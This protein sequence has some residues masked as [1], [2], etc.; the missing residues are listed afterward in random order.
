MNLSISKNKFNTSLTSPK[1]LN[2]SYDKKIN[3][4]NVYHHKH[5]NSTANQDLN[6]RG[7]Y[8]KTNN[9][10]NKSSVLLSDSDC[11]NINTS[12]EYSTDK[13]TKNPLAADRSHYKS[14]YK[15][16]EKR[17]SRNNSDEKHKEKEKENNNNSNN[18][19]NSNIEKKNKL[20]SEKLNYSKSV[21]YEDNIFNRS[22]SKN[23][24]DNSL[25]EFNK[26]ENEE[27]TSKRVANIIAK[28]K[29]I[30]GRS[31]STRDVKKIK[32][33]NSE[34]EKIKKNNIFTVLKTDKNKSEKIDFDAESI[35][36]DIYNEHELENNELFDLG[37]I[38]SK[39]FSNKKIKNVSKNNSVSK[40]KSK[41][42]IKT[43]KNAKNKLYPYDTNSE[44][45]LTFTN[46]DTTKNYSNNLHSYE[47]T[48]RISSRKIKN[49]F[50]NII[51]NTNS[52]R[53]LTGNNRSFSIH[54]YSNKIKNIQTEKEKILKLKERNNEL[55]LTLK[56]E[57]KKVDD[58]EK[59]NKRIK[60]K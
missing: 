57:R 47:T 2:Q 29:D 41:R 60:F 37:K 25:S 26:S 32:T 45:C 53:L 5:S 56:N 49:T 30:L 52:N 14:P 22:K 35:N 50:T 19:N 33:K 3:T 23:K 39:A 51:N 21:I 9:F 40:S 10:K 27:F 15:A 7:K 55:K 44:N 28:T 4:N 1:N 59:K 13:I 43:T 16:L 17:L 36:N 31:S 12:Q 18:H 6:Y 11:L 20:H 8:K 42:K 48:S 54:N 58:L 38:K 34:N 46:N 24:A